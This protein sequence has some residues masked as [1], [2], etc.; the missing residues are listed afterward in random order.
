MGRSLSTLV[1][2]FMN[3]SRLLCFAFASVFAACVSPSSPS[4]CRTSDDCMGKEVCVEGHCLFESVSDSG[5]GG[6]TASGGGQGG[7]GSDFIDAGEEDSGIPD[8]GAQ[9]AGPVDAG[10][11]DAGHVDAGSFD[12]GSAIIGDACQSDTDCA[13]IVTSPGASPWCKLTQ[14]PSGLAY[15]GGYCTRRCSDSGE[16]GTGNTCVYWLGPFGEVD[17]ICTKGCPDAAGCREGYSCRD[18]GLVPDVYLKSCFPLQADGGLPPPWNAGQGAAGAAGTSCTST[19]Q[20][21]SCGPS[22]SFEC[23]PAVLTDGGASPYPNGMCT[24]DCSTTLDDA[25]CGNRGSCNPYL[26]EAD[27]HGEVLRWRCDRLCTGVST[28]SCNRVGYVCDTYNE[29]DVC[30]PDCRLDGG[31]KCPSGSSCSEAQGVCQ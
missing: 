23:R 16:C 31:L 1:G 17:N 19:N 8:A 24:G 30:R 28:V 26:E 15:A 22:P 18:L 4:G 20:A 6:G 14:S 12:A 10:A 11:V 5:T 2:S 27:L 13:G 29:L 7:G 25:W 21:T 3:T 9:D